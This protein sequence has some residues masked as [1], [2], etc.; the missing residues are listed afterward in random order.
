MALAAE[1][2]DFWATGIMFARKSKTMGSDSLG[3]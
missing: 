3:I 1:A 2:K